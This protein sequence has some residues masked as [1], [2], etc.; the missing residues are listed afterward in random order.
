MLKSAAAE[1]AREETQAPQVNVVERQVTSPTVAQQAAAI[2]EPSAALT[3][4]AMDASPNL[5]EEAP[6]VATSSS[7]NQSK[8]TVDAR[9]VAIDAVDA[10]QATVQTN[11]PG[12]SPAPS[13][14]Q[15]ARSTTEDA[16]PAAVAAA[17]EAAN[18][19]PST[20]N[21]SAPSSPTI[22]RNSFA[23]NNAMASYSRWCKTARQICGAACRTD[24]CRGSTPASSTEVGLPTNVPTAAAVGSVAKS[25]ISLPRSPTAIPLADA[26]SSQAAAAARATSVPAAQGSSRPSDA[27]APQVA[28]TGA[29]NFER[30]TPAARLPVAPISPADIPTEPTKTAAEVPTR[31]PLSPSRD[32]ASSATAARSVDSAAAP[33]E[34]AKIDGPGGLRYEPQPTIGSINRPAR[35]EPVVA[36]P[37]TARFIQK[38]AGGPLV[39]DGRAREPAE[40]FSRRRGRKV[41]PSEANGQPIELTEKAVELGLEFLARH[42][43][44]DGSWSLH[45]YGAG[46]RGYERE[47]SQLRSD[48]AATGLALLAFLG[49]GYDH[50]DDK[51][52]PQ[53]RQG[54]EYLVKNQKSDGD[55]FVTMDSLSN[56]SVWLY[57]HGIAAIA[58]CEAVGMTGDAELRGPAQKAIDF[59]VAA[60]HKDRRMALCTGPRFGYVR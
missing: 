37:G 39:I 57:S 30:K 42:Q 6:Q 44:E 11:A 46:K 14:F 2:P 17:G 5:S 32:L 23:R 56:K 52:S 33:L 58:L 10:P 8:R 26:T 54:L 24:R 3:P 21:A 7:P 49:A 22:S 43:S 20:T 19:T 25:N 16:A 15:V 36:H 50:Y 48:T 45:N 51:Y 53:I 18:A 41:D 1:S 35:R 55:L 29:A 31:N 60:Q 47:T 40:A 4:S 9:A 28:T 13:E 38:S 59:I 12:P 34:V 27:S